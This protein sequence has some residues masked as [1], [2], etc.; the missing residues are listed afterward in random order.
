MRSHF[1]IRKTPKAQ[2]LAGIDQGIWSLKIPPGP[3]GN[4]RL[5]QLD[6][7]C[8]HARDRLPW[9]P[10]VTLSLRARVSV[11]DHPGTWGFG[12]WIW[13]FTSPL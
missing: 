12:F 4:Y 7:Y 13:N 1:E 10:P 3:K 6:D 5:A 11:S 9:K 8:T 2:V